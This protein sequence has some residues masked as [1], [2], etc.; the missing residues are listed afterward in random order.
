MYKA[1]LI[2]RMPLLNMCSRETKRLPA[3]R[4]AKLLGCQAMLPIERHG[5][6]SELKPSSQFVVYHIDNGEVPLGVC[7]FE[8]VLVERDGRKEKV[9]ASGNATS[10]IEYDLDAGWYVTFGGM[11][12]HQELRDYMFYCSRTPCTVSEI[13]AMA[14]ECKADME[15]V[16]T[17]ARF[18]R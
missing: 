11:I 13:D 1:K 18:I 15:H 9:L 16:R 3:A 2:T 8:Y 14:E 12:P 4:V 5:G 7:R 10:M 6:I 17:P